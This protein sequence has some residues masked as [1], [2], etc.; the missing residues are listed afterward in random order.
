MRRDPE[1]TPATGLLPL[2]DNNRDPFCAPHGEVEAAG[3][4]SERGVLPGLRYL[5]DF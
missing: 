1:I 5:A 2:L 4:S 3:D